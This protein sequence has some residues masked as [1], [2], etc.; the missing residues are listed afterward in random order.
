MSKVTQQKCACTDCVCVI[1][2]TDAV[3]KGGKIYCSQAC[4]DGHPGHS[5]CASE[6]CG[7]KGSAAA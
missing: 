5:A 2:V 4:A 7:C 6:S 1:A 3:T